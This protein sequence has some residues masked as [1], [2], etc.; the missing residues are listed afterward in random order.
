MRRGDRGFT[1]LELLI[2]LAIVATLLAVAF[3]GLRVA[4]AAWRQGE[5]RAEAHQHVRGVA[6]VL[7]RALGATYPYRA[8]RGLGP[9]PVL[10][11]EGTERRLEF[12][13]A[14][15]PFP[16][17]LPVAFTAVVVSL[18]EGDR[19]G[20]VVRQ[21]PL[22]NREPF[23]EA[24]VVFHDPTVTT[25]ALR[26]MDGDGTWQESWDGAAEK[27][28]PRAIRLTLGTSLGGRAQSLPP[29]TVSLRVNQ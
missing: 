28:T 7:A 1:L 16:F 22:P 20:L 23:S 3:G 13:T 12:V 8:P 26:Y 11:F 6:V 19:P 27:G 2:A 9:D 4:A 25:L 14:A 18:E 5:D 24:P 21:R 17:P 15:T 10:L 29:L